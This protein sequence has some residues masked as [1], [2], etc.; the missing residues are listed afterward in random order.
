MIQ[1]PL[2]FVEGLIAQDTLLARSLRSFI[3]KNI[4]R[5]NVVAPLA[6]PAQGADLPA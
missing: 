5:V 3:G 1:F 2:V 4:S 6:S